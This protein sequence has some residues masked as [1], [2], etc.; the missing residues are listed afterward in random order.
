MDPRIDEILQFWFGTPPDGEERPSGA[1]LWF[2]KSHRMDR[3][4]ERRFGKLLPMAK[5]GQ[6]D[7]WAG[8]PKGRLALILVL[9]QFPRF[10]HRDTPQAFAT[11][12]KALNLCLDGLDDEVD[13][14]LSTLER[15][16]FYMPAMHSEDPDIQLTSVEVF[17]ELAASA[18]PEH[19]GF[20][21]K[22]LRQAERHREVV[23]RFERFPHR[24]AILGRSSSSEEAT[25]LQ[26]NDE[27]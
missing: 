24:N 20:C 15:V 4:V 27:L 18:P 1:E 5:A 26:Q 21:D 23:E 16:F 17:G 8:T 12:E 19:A 6:L 10:V 11:D 3:L 9:N 14:K 13:K 25:F 7:A 2:G 22:L